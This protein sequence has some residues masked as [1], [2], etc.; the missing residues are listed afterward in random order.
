MVL[1][2]LLV[3]LIIVFQGQLIR[4]KK[5]FL[6]VAFF[7]VLVL[8]GLRVPDGAGSD[9]YAYCEIFT[10]LSN[11]SFTE[12]LGSFTHEIGFYL[13]CHYL[14]FISK[15][16][17][18]LIFFSSLM[19]TL[20]VFTFINK[21]SRIP[22]LSVVLYITLLFFFN[23]LNLMRFG[24]AGSFLLLSYDSIIQRRLLKFLFYVVVASMFH[25]SALIFII[26][27]YI[28]PLVL[29][30]KKIILISVPFI[31]VA[32]AFQ[33]AFS[34]LIVLN[35]RYSSYDSGF[36]EFYQS[37]FANYLIALVNLFV[38]IFVYKN[39]G[40]NLKEL[41]GDEKF[42]FLSVFIS[43]IFS[44]M[45]IK[46]MVITRFVMMFSIVEIVYIANVLYCMPKLKRQKF[47]LIILIATV[48][49][50]MVV[51]TY[52]PEWYF[53]NPYSNILLK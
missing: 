39:G 9:T 40:K 8:S 44:I 14:S 42:Y 11:S 45:A 10:E 12:I 20:S 13:M 7:E 33:F 6:V 36:G 53:I 50:T 19:M 28:Y 34:L 51:L 49:Q 46:V 18:I 43:C 1:F 31:I 47:I 5:L 37:S 27:Y 38:L 30:V 29:N 17:Q 16:P 22:W 24:L 32:Y 26:A 52:K 41:E 4:N 35:P 21:K 23:N 2:F 25:F 3:I 48:T 15:D